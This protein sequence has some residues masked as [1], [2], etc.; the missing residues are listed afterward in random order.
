VVAISLQL[1]GFLAF[2]IFAELP[3][4]SSD[5]SSIFHAVSAPRE[6]RVVHCLVSE[7][8]EPRSPRLTR[9]LQG[10]LSG[11]IQEQRASL[12]TEHQHHYTLPEYQCDCSASTLYNEN[13]IWHTIGPSTRIHS[14]HSQS[15]R[16]YPFTDLQDCPE[17]S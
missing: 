2:H 14:R 4:I 1:M 15:Q 17:R 12:C 16:G 7:I 11:F 10:K 5:I 13:S 8:A 3:E 9:S 6:P